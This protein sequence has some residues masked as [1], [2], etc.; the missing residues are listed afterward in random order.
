MTDLTKLT[1]A[2]ARKGLAGKSFSATELTGAYLQAIEAANPKL[3]AYVAVTADQALSMAKASDAK[4]AAGQGGPLEG[5][6]LGIKDLFATKGVHTQAASHILDGFKP[7]YEST[8]T[9]QLSP[10]HCRPLT[11]SGSKPVNSV[12]SAFAAVASSTAERASPESCSVFSSAVFF[13]SAM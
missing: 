13:S 8:I 1:L 4:L 2:D 12:T 3:N 6:P 10:S 7:E 11:D 9:S 5:I